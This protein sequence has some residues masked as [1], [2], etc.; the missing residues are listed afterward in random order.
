MI[1][2]DDVPCHIHQLQH[3]KYIYFVHTSVP[4][5]GTVWLDSLLSDRVALSV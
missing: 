2:I 3:I 4:S 1:Y 5:F